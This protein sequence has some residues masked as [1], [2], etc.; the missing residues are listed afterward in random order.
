MLS[1]GVRSSISRS[2]EFVRGIA[3]AAP[4]AGTVPAQ[5]RSG[6]ALDSHGEWTS[7]VA[8]P[9]RA[10]D[11]TDLGF[12]LDSHGTWTSNVT[13]AIQAAARARARACALALLDRGKQG[14]RPKIEAESPPP[15]VPKKAKAIRMAG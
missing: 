9:L 2:G 4:P 10:L 13:P 14:I 3:L 7:N 6:F 15:A 11:H 12:A 5:S 8:P 1:R